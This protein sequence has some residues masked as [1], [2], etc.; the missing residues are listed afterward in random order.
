MSTPPVE[1]ASLDLAPA[2]FASDWT[3][4]MRP[5]SSAPH[6]TQRT[7][8]PPTRPPPTVDRHAVTR[9][10]P[11]PPR[12]APR[13]GTS[14]WSLPESDTPS[15]PPDL[16]IPSPPLSGIDAQGTLSPEEVPADVP[17]DLPMR[18]ITGVTREGMLPA[19]VG[20][21][22]VVGL[23]VGIV[24]VNRP[25]PLQVVTSTSANH[26]PPKDL[27][28]TFPAERGTPGVTSVLAPAPVATDPPFVPPAD[29]F[30]TSDPDAIPSATHVAVAPPPPALP[31]ASH[32]VIRPTA[33]VRAPDDGRDL[34]YVRP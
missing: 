27:N 23:F 26:G 3:D 14:V 15:V 33:P 18:R 1:G 29:S 17:Y 10:S 5:S 16:G 22:L 25:R 30:P 12:P 32:P 8:L 28:S 2:D 20:S 19:I 7:E 13:R 11:Q 31:A 6:T 24:I 4:P 21:T 34:L 9:T